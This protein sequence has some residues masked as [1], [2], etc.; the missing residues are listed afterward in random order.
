M[1]KKIILDIS[2]LMCYN[3]GTVKQD[4][5]LTFTAL[6]KCSMNNK[7]VLNGYRNPYYIIKRRYA[8]G[9][10]TVTDLGLTAFCDSD[11]LIVF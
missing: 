4:N 5:R 11:N 7:Q 10:R 6:A 2:R 1:H 9:I 8:Y 3:K